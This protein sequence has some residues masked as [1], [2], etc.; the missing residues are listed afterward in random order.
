MWLL[1][2]HCSPSETASLDR[3]NDRGHKVSVGCPRAIHDYFYH[4]RSVDVLSQ[5]HY[6]YLIGRK[7]RRAWP[8]L[9]WWL[10]DMCVINAFQL[11]SKGQ[12]HPGQLRFREEL[13]YELLQQLPV[14]DKPRQHGGRQ[15]PPGATAAIHSSELAAEDRD[16]KQCSRQPGRR[17]RTNYICS[18]CQVHLCLGACF[19]AYHADV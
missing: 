3:W 18:E 7:A 9:A 19:R 10:L 5:L 11:W 1:Y 16:C 8:R 2:N 15:P 14:D 13:M 6:A 4:A 17:K 12:Q